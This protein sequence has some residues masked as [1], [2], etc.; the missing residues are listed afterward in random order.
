MRWGRHW[1]KWV[2]PRKTPVSS[3][4]PC[5]KILSTNLMAKTPLRRSSTRIRPF[6]MR[7][8][9]AHLN[10]SILVRW[11]RLRWNGC[12][13]SKN[14]IPRLPMLSRPRWMEA[15]RAHC[16]WTCVTRAMFTGGGCAPWHTTRG[17]PA[18]FTRW[19]RHKSWRACRPLDGH[20]LSMRMLRVGPCM[21]SG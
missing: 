15:G 18:M 1:L 3:S 11:Q 9:S 6:W 14:L 8:I 21:Q 10:Y 4:K 13:N 20:I 17:S 2:C 19:H 5:G 16:G 12:P 7:S